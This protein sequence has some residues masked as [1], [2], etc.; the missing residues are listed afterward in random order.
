MGL[1]L[2]VN[3]GDDDI[4]IFVY[5]YLYICIPDV[6]YLTGKRKSGQDMGLVWQ[7]NKGDD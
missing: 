2:R 5:I 3:E 7:V 4:C 1:L 6:V